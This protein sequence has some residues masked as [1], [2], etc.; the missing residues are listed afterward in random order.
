MWGNRAEGSSQVFPSAQDYQDNR[1]DNL[2]DNSVGKTLAINHVYNELHQLLKMLSPLESVKRHQDVFA[3]HSEAPSWWSIYYHKIIKAAKLE[4]QLHIEVVEALELIRAG[5]RR[6]ESED[7][8]KILKSTMQV[9][10]RHFGT[11]PRD[12]IEI[13]PSTGDIET[14]LR[15]EIELNYE[16]NPGDMDRRLKEE[17][18]TTLVKSATGM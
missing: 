8:T 4:S 14:F 6:V 16:V 11:K 1:V 2:V 5:R 17:I 15:Q 7:V 10:D 13:V 9:V 12:A 3:T 18:M